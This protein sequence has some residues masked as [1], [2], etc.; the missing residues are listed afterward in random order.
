MPDIN[1]KIF[2]FQVLHFSIIW[3]ET[4]TS[5]KMFAWA[6][7]LGPSFSIYSRFPIAKDR[8]EESN[9]EVKEMATSSHSLITQEVF[10]Q[11]TSLLQW[12]RT[13]ASQ[14]LA[15]E[16][17]LLLCANRIEYAPTAA[18]VHSIMLCFVLKTRLPQPFWKMSRPMFIL[19]LLS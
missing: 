11:A 3:V 17:C 4:N 19:F 12:N 15:I 8:A 6:P 9:S 16:N 2:L 10:S 14:M 18:S 13:N 5:F 7:T 1:I